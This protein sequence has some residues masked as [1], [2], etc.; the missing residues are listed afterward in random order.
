MMIHVA[1]V[2]AALTL[3][4]ILAGGVGFA[5]GERAARKRVYFEGDES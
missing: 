2:A 4:A 5:M 3:M 1:H